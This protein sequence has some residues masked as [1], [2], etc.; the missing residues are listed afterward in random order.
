MIEKE[1]YI[2]IYKKGI[3]DGKEHVGSFNDLKEIANIYANK[4]FE[5]NEEKDIYINNFIIH[6]NKQF[7]EVHLKNNKDAKKTAKTFEVDE[8]FVFSKII[9]LQMYQDFVKEILEKSDE[10][11]I[12]ILKRKNS[13]LLEENSLL[14]Q[15]LEQSK[16]REKML[17]RQLNIAQ[18]EIRIKELDIQL[19]KTK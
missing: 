12:D 5:T 4:Y 18:E 13:K 9:E 11:E 16:T 19:N 1:K 3:T 14:L 10:S 17:E 7:I 6:D 2:K 8:P 15:A